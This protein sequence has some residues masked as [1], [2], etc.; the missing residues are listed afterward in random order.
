MFRY[1]FSKNGASYLTRINFTGDDSKMFNMRD[2]QSRVYLDYVNKELYYYR[3][4]NTSKNICLLDYDGALLKNIS[5]AEGNVDAFTVFGDFLYLQKIGTRVIQEMHVSTGVTSR[6][7]S[8][9][10]PFTR[11]NDLAIVAQSQYPTGEMKQNA[12]VEYSL[13]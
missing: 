12:A 13:A 9:P 4:S 3:M 11:L 2:G 7:I 10:K 1:I 6:N 5:F 8:L